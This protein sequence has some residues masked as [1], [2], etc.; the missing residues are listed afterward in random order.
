[1][2]YGQS[3]SYMFNTAT[4]EAQAVI[5]VEDDLL[6]SHDFLDYFEAMSPVQNGSFLHTTIAIV[7]SL[8]ALICTVISQSH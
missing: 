1:M 7:V 2:H 6:F 5:I 4:P 8:C 3:L